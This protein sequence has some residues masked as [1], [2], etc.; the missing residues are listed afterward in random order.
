MQ[1]HRGLTLKRAQKSVTSP[2]PGNE[3][4]CSR[5]GESRLNDQLTRFLA[6]PSQDRVPLVIG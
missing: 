5:I 1:D 6:K 4:L 2:H 3:L